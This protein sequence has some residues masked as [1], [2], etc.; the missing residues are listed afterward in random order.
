MKN[1]GFTLVMGRIYVRKEGEVV[2]DSAALAY[3]CWMLT[4]ADSS[5]ESRD[6]GR[7]RATGGSE[8]GGSSPPPK[9]FWS[10]LPLL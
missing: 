8:I 5:P 10:P 7:L 1:G 4:P 6:A 9:V 3:Q 2:K